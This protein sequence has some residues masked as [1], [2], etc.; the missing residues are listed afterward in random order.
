M[1]LMQRPRLKG[2]V[3]TMKMTERKVRRREQ[4]PGPWGEAGK[5]G[6]K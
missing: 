4:G 1:T 6:A 5:G 3:T 2:R